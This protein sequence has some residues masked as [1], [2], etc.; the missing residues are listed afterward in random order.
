M[1]IEHANGQMFRCE[2]NW[3]KEKCLENTRHDDENDGGDENN[4]RTPPILILN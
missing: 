2:L 4:N 3:P 1:L